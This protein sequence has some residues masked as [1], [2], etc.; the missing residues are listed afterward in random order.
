MLIN[1]PILIKFGVYVLGMMT[2][3][4]GMYIVMQRFNLFEYIFI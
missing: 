4:M 1:G 2:W 3:V